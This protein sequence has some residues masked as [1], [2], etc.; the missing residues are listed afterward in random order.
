MDEGQVILC[1]TKIQVATK[2]VRKETTSMC[3]AHTMWTACLT[4]KLYWLFFAKTVDWT[5]IR[6]SWS[7]EKP[8]IN[9]F[10]NI[11]TTGD[12][13]NVNDKPFCGSFTLI[14]YLQGK[15]YFKHILLFQRRVVNIIYPIFQAWP[16]WL[17]VER[18]PLLGVWE[19]S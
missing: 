9:V 4:F 16:W 12:K 17:F 15:I 18:P 6:I 13:P 19:K 7:S 8:N 2:Q 11:S 1:L 3:V 14:V 5:I 10:V